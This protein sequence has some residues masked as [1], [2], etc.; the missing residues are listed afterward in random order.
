MFRNL[1]TLPSYI[2]FLK[3][4]SESQFEVT[5]SFIEEIKLILIK[6]LKACEKMTPMGFFHSME[7]EVIC[8]FGLL[9]YTKQSYIELLIK[10]SIFQILEAYLTRTE[11]DFIIASLLFT[12]DYNRE[13]VSIKSES[14]QEEYLGPRILLENSI[15]KGSERLALQ[16]LEVVRTLQLTEITAFESWGLNLL[17]RTLIERAPES[18]P[19]M[20]SVISIL[21]SAL[22]EPSNTE[23]F[24]REL[25]FE[26]LNLIKEKVSS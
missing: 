16:A 4:P 12:F 20:E 13:N 26:K 8:W 6:L 9:S 17:A 14:G 21:I 11:S 15:I 23:Y 22:E 1:V 2:E 7:R 24:I 5:I 18:K 3:S 10:Y 19:I 25:D